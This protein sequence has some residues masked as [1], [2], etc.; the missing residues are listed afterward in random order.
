[1]RDPDLFSNGAVYHIYNRGVD[2]RTIFS[3]ASDYSRFIDGIVAFNEVGRKAV[4]SLSHIAK[5]IVNEHPYVRTICYCLMPNHFHLML[6]QVESGGISEYMRRLGTG[7]TKYFNKR[8]ERSGRLLESAY[9]IKRIE[10]TDQFNHLSRYIHLNPLKLAGIDLNKERIRWNQ[11]E[12]ILSRYPWSSFRHYAGAER[13]PFIDMQTGLQYI[14]SP[15]DY[16]RFL[17][18][19]MESAPSPLHP[20]P[21]VG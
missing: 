6:E 20:T 13:Q 16:M 5:R 18:E 7:Y 10:T 15:S 1:M 4:Q 21:G 3:D 11:A 2:K 9:K 12:A 14:G 8:N 17:S 19:W